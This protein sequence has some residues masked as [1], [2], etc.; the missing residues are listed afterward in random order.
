MVY[1]SLQ[2][3]VKKKKKKKKKEKKKTPTTQAEHKVCTFMTVERLSTL[4]VTLS[5]IKK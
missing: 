5:W 1:L 3:L 4:S 2:C